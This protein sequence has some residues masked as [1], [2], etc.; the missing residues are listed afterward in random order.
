[1]IATFLVGL[2]VDSL[3]ISSFVLL[4][5]IRGE[6]AFFGVRISHETYVTRGR[7]MLHQYRLWLVGALVVFE[8]AGALLSSPGTWLY[9]RGFILAGLLIT[10]CVLFARFHRYA[11]EFALPDYPAHNVTLVSSANVTDY[12]NRWLEVAA[13]AAV[14]IP[15][16]L[17]VYAY[18][19]M[20]EVVP[21]HWNIKGEPDGWVRKSFGKVFLLPL[22]TVYLQ[23]LFLMIKRGLATTR[24][25]VPK[26]HSAEYLSLKEGLLLANIRLL[27]LVRLFVAVLLG[28]IIMNLLFS[29]VLD[30]GD[31]KFAVT[32]IC[33]AAA[34]SLV[35]VV[36]V[37][38]RK[39]LVINRELKSLGIPIVLRNLVEQGG[40]SGGGLFYYN[41]LD[42]SLFVEKLAGFGYTFNFANP[43]VILYLVYLA[44][45]PV[46]VVMLVVGL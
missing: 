38:L 43:R 4:P 33:S 29:T 34:L 42:P 16:L 41:P 8:V 6:E 10:A 18:P 30:V 27:E 37:S 36:I 11:R 3:V 46:L 22:M 31:L 13:T 24:I 28:G 17:V 23:G 5:T 45:L 25:A 9:W 40:W 20:P 44:G 39:M 35:A 26:E 14:V 2:F 15:V 32:L 7:T 1:M 19:S 12:K 21:I